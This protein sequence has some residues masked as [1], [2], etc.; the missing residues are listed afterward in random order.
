MPFY[1]LPCSSYVYGDIFMYMYVYVYV[2]IDIY[3]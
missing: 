3:V 2:I 1:I